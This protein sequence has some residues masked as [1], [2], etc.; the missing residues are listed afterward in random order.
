MQR[1]FL[2]IFINLI[3]F[4]CMSTSTTYQYA[5]GSANVYII[6][7]D[8]LEYIPVRPEES[9]T[10]FYSGGDPKKVALKPEEFRN[11]QNL[12]EAARK[13][14]EVHMSDRI[15]TSGMITTFSGSERT[16]VILIPGSTEI[17]TIEAELKKLLNN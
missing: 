14:Q 1:A 5:D 11:V 4:A 16:Q 7:P 10:G 12:L 15:K 13:N 2:F 8:S 17:T 6:R 9:S 3:T